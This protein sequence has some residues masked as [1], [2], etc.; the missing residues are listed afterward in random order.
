MTKLKPYSKITDNVYAIHEQ[1]FILYL[2][3][4]GKNILIDT[5]ISALGK[6]IYNKINLI[7]EGRP[8]DHIFLTHSHYDHTGSIPYLQK[9]LGSSIFGSARTVELL[10]KE[11]VRLFIKDMND[12]F[13]KVLGITE[14]TEFPEPQNINALNEETIFE[15]NSEEYIRVMPTPGHTKCSISFLLMP[16]KI[17]F[18]GDSAGVIERNGKIKPLF[19]SNFR[20]YVTSLKKLISLEADTLALP[21]NRY[22][23]GHEKVK[24]FLEKSL[25]STIELKEKILNAIESGTEAE[26]ISAEVMGREFPLPVVEGPQKAFNINLISMVKAVEKFTKEKSS[27]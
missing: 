22:I 10:K 24:I 9:K 5:A 1:M 17:L 26:D 18:P 11:N 23:K 20:E 21:H 14:K 7:L 19:L 4:G 25:L 6:S 12:R 3:T 15:L 2:I 8:L 13:N 27:E 16:Q